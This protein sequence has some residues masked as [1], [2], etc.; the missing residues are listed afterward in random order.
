MAPWISDGQPVDAL[1]RCLSGQEVHRQGV[2]HQSGRQHADASLSVRS[3]RAERRR[4]AQAGHVR[5]R[6]HRKRRSS[7]PVLTLPYSALQYRY[8]VNRV[9]VVNGDKLAM[10]ELAVGERLGDRIEIVDGR[11]GGRTRRRHRRRHP[12][13]RRAG[14]RDQTAVTQEG[15]QACC[16]NSASAVRSSRR[17]SSCRSWCWGSFSFRDLGVDLFPKADPATVSVALPLPGASPD[18]MSTSVIEPM[19]NAHQRHL[20]HRRNAVAIVRRRAARS[21]SGSCSSATSTT[22]R[23]T[24]AR[25]WRARCGTCRR[26]LL[27]PVITK[28]DPDADPVMCSD[29]LVRRDEPAHADRD[30]RQA[31]QRA[32]RDGRRRRRSQHRAAIA[33]A[34]S[35]SSSTSRS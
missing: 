25:R 30:R 24:C 21:P 19:E 31:D 8:G 1:G 22:R 27:P 26:Q 2:A 9:F 15:A 35:T 16:L 29:R 7:T 20:R 33:R 4:A 34:K 10:R 11:E 32:H 28:V 6:A 17:C 5:A 12:G 23:T 14:R 13:R 3:A 18:E